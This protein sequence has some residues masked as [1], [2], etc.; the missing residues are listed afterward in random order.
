[1]TADASLLMQLR[2]HLP[3][4]RVGER[5]VAHVILATPDAIGTLSILDLA[6]RSGVSEATV[7][8]L[9][10]ALGFRGYTT[11][12]VRLITELATQ[13]GTGAALAGGPATDIQEGDDLATLVQK[14]LRMDIQALVDTAAVLDTAAIAA[15]VALLV[16]ARRVECYG[17][18]GSGPV[19]QDAAYRLMR[20]GVTA[21]SCTDS[22][23]Q[24]VHAS[25]LGSADVALCV[26]HSGET[27]DT[28]DA[29]RAARE[30]GAHT[31]AMTSFPQSPLAQAAEVRLL[32]AAVG[33]KWRSDA[34]PARIAQLSVMD[35][36]CVAI[37]VQQGAKASVV[38]DKI[39]RGLARKQHGQGV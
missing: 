19:V 30:A 7:M 16:A 28:L 23:L 3:T 39:E 24:V 11:F 20:V 17:V 8:R 27:Q 1:M 35:A 9:C 13:Q 14:V 26:S 37:Q 18:G 33:S 31:I 21:S 36:L 22:H 38:L 12:K 4:L 15:A 25:L 6:E 5:K 32:T 10:Y 29:L 2:A 34:I